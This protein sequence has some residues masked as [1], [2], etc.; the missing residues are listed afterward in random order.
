MSET[1][2]WNPNPAPVPEPQQSQQSGLRTTVMICYVLYLVAFINGV[3]AIIGLII[4]YVKRSDA[5]GTVWATHFDNLIFTF[6]VM[7]AAFVLML[8]TLPVSLL[9]LVALFQ[10]D[11]ALPAISA[12]AFPILLWM[13]IFPILFIWFLYRMIRGLIRAAD[14]RAY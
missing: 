5:A 7:L 8:A 4:A 3:T 11:F 10:Q 14:D 12:L 13:L 6:W 9:S 1:S 2:G